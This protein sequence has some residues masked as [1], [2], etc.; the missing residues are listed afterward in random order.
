MDNSDGQRERPYPILNLKEMDKADNQKVFQN[1]SYK[2]SSL[3]LDLGRQN[4][5]CKA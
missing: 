4:N 5:P 1:K 2:D 3:N